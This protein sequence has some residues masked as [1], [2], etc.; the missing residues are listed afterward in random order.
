[1]ANRHRGEAP[2]EIG[3][4]KLALKLT[5]GGLAELEDLFGTRGL[6]ALGDRLT[7]ASFSTRDLIGILKIGLKG[8]GHALDEAE[9]EAFALE[10]GLQPIVTAVARMFV[11]TFG[12]APADPP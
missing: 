8:A 4:R 9:I 12:E 2:L 5:L 11:L 6:N 7:G 10:D 1:M 3:G